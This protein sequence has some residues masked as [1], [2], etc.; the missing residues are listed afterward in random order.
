[1]EKRNQ[2]RDIFSW[3]KVQRDLGNQVCELSMVDGEEIGLQHL[4]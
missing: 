2:R 3:S 4:S 1:M